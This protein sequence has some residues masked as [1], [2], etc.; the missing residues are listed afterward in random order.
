MSSQ[1]RSARTGGCHLTT[2]LPIEVRQRIDWHQ[3]DRSFAEAIAADRQ[4]PGTDIQHANR[5]GRRQKL[6]DCRMDRTIRSCHF[7]VPGELL[8]HS[9]T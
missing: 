7:D 1:I 9:L 2:D 4:R 8:F 3:L 6:C 5:P